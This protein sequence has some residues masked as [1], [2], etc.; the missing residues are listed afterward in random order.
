MRLVDVEM[1]RDDLPA[2]ALPVDGAVDVTKEARRSARN[3]ARNGITKRSCSAC[4][5]LSGGIPEFA[6]G[7]TE[8]LAAQ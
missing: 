8:I 2:I 3:R 5:S 7:R 4:D 6:D 1:I